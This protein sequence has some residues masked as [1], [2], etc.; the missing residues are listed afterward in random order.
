MDLHQLRVFVAVASQGSFA[1][2]ARELGVAPSAVTRAIAALEQTLGVL[3][4]NR[5]TRKLVLT[6]PGA[7]YLD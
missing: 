4:M 2:A 5:T 6:E 3:L 7:L 1:A